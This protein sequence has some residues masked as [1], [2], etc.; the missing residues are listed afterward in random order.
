MSGQRQGYLFEVSWEVCNKVGG[1]YT[2]ITSKL[3]EAVASYGDNYYLLGPDLK[4]NADFEETDEGCW[5][6]IREKIALKDIHC[7]FGRWKIAGEPKAILVNSG[8]KYNK[9]QLL[10]TIWEEHGVD[11]IAGGWDYIEPVM[12]SYACG[13]VIKTIYNILAKPEG[14]TAVAHFHEWMCGAGLLFLK[15]QAPEIGRVFTTHATILG[16]SLAGSGVDIYTNMEQI[17]P[18]KEATAHNITAKYSMEVASAR[19][20]DCFTTVSNITASEASNFLGCV[21]DLV[22]PNGL[23]ISNIP[24]L[25]QDR[26]SVLNVRQHLLHKASHFLGRE[27]PDHTKIMIISGRYEFSNKGVDV[28]LNALAHLEK[29]LGE[30]E[31][32]LVYLAVIAGHTGLNPRLQSDFAQSDTAG[33][34]IATHRLSYEA[35]DPILQTCNRLKFVNDHNNRIHIIFIPAYLDGNDGLINI[36]YY[37]ALS[38]CDLG[39]FPSY[40]EP[41]GYTP[42]ECAAYSVPTVTTDQ[43][44]FGLW[45][46]E[47][48]G[49]SQG[50]ILLERKNRSNEEIEEHLYQVLL[51]FVSQ[52]DEA[53]MEQRI[54]ARRVSEKADWREF[55]KFYLTGYNKA[56]VKVQERLSSL[57]VR[58][59]EHDQKHVFAGAVST[60]PHFRH[61][62]A[63]SNLP[64]GLT[65]L[66]ELSRNIWWAWHPRV[67]DLFA[68]MSPRLWAETDN[69]PVKFLE[70]ISHDTLEEA[71]NNPL[72][73]ARYEHTLQMFDHYMEDRK[74]HLA[75]A[76]TEDINTMHPVAY[77]STEYGLHESIPIYSGGLGTLSG[78][79][80]KTAGDL[81]I[82]LVGIGLFYKNGYF[83]QV[84]DSH[85]IQ[86]AEYP[87]NN[88]S[89]LPLHLVQD[90]SGNEVRIS[91]DL[92][93]R[94]LYA[95]IWE[96]KVGKTSLYLL[97]TNLPQN[98]TQDRHI[99]DRLYASDQRTRIEQEI[100]LGVGGVK[101]LRKLGLKPRVYHINEGHSAFLL[102]ERISELMLEEG[103]SFAEAVEMVKGSSIFTTHT[104]VE[105]GNERFSKEL[106]EYYFSGFVRRTGITWSQFW[107]LGQKEQGDDK[108]FFMTVLALKLSN[109]SNAVSAI[110][111]QISRHMWKDVWKGYHTTDI[112]IRHITNGIHMMSYI[113]PRMKD[114]LDGFLGLNWHNCLSDPKIWRKIGDIPDT[115]LW[116]TRF[117]IKQRFISFLRDRISQQYG[118]YGSS[119]LWQEEILSKVD[120]T[121][122]IIGFARR[123]APYKRADMLFTDLDRLDR[124]LNNKTRPVHIVFAGKAHPNDDMGKNL[125]RRIVEICK[126]ERFR[127]KILFIEDYNIRVAR[128]L[129]QGVDLWLNNPRRPLEASGTSG[130]KVIANGVL[131]ASVSDGWWPEGYDGSNG[132][133]IGPHVVN[134][135]EP[136]ANADEE[137]ADSLYNLLENTIVPM[138]YER[139]A[140][141]LPTRWIQMIKRSMMSLGP[142]FNTERMLLEYYNDMYLPTAKRSTDLHRDSYAMAKEIA[143]WKSKLHTRFASLRLLDFVVEGFRGDVIHVDDVLSVTVNIDAG[144]MNPDEIRVEMIVGKKGT[145]TDEKNDKITYVPLGMANGENPSLLTFFTHYTIPENGSYYYGVRVMPYHPLLSS[146]VEADLIFW[147]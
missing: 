48:F 79:H 65:R 128:H 132:W 61:F 28:F 62:T 120:S 15:K 69:N 96:I 104:P 83:R 141:G 60:Q 135:T 56:L 119:K 137:D 80:L 143:D 51:K 72:Y 32:I 112:P 99:T 95:N 41:W 40:Y 66:R 29:D 13:E 36:P 94:T 84:I 118:A 130:Q 1:I 93:G 34:H 58:E 63:V 121:S 12:F 27:F 5:R 125:V 42:L 44:G 9:D 142:L 53:L 57:Q 68:S 6:M 50:I 11:S 4:T 98:T 122:L 114:L 71:A 78:D 19:E 110:H 87:E 30:N 3:R 16:R 126:D 10:Y 85:G 109:M 64:K 18:Q 54:A 147:G 106:M 108:P 105:A 24:D 21:P 90:D 86:I 134:Y 124:I 35:S 136:G 46:R 39:I 101:L 133:N 116:R 55:Y 22:T 37:E 52:S 117:D 67:F 43:A 31:S 113:A 145:D 17:S 8:K 97:N 127:G 33:G 70:I 146:K 111:G 91:I 2:V 82:P 140:S 38:G 59:E 115:L 7:R 25:S 88:P 77:F 131:N 76:P 107:E 138:F 103:L 144:K 74:P 26:T 47:I 81:N 45:V 73:M 102:L 75:L 92:P 129:V 20:A 89:D 23:D 14:H 139:D 100:L 123:F 49:E